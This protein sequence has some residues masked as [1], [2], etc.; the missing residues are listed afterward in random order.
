MPSNLE[1]IYNVLIDRILS[2]CPE[3]NRRRNLTIKQFTALTNLRENKSIVIK[4]ADKGSNVVIQNVDDYIK[5]G[6]RQLGDEKFYR[7]LDYDPTE[8]F[9]NKIHKELECMFAEKEISEKTVL[10]LI[11]GGKRRSI[12]YM[13]PKIHKNKVPPPGRPIVSSVN[14]PTEKIS[15]LLILATF[16][17]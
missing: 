3:L 12:F 8:E 17:P 16:C 1:H 9:R 14:S 4:K 5:E 11:K 2:D 7:K 15:M 13:L 10:F 6:L